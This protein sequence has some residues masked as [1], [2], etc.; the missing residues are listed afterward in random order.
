MVTMANMGNIHI[1]EEY[2]D[3]EPFELEPQSDPLTGKDIVSGVLGLVKSGMEKM[4][5]E[6]SKKMDKIE[7]L[8]ERFQNKTDDELRQIIMGNNSL[9]EK[10]AAKKLLSERQ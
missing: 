8:T 9:E 3:I 1:D 2:A 10:A 5:A 4:S 7:Q 6:Y